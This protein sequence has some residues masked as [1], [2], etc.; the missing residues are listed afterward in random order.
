MYI[1]ILYNWLTIFANCNLLTQTP[2]AFLL[3][4]QYNTSAPLREKTT[5]KFQSRK[6]PHLSVQQNCCFHSTTCRGHRSKPKHH[7]QLWK[8]T[9]GTPPHGGTKNSP[10]DH[11]EK[12]PPHLEGHQLASRLWR[13]ALVFSCAQAC[14][15]KAGNTFSILNAWVF[16][17]NMA[18]FFPSKICWE[19]KKGK[20]HFGWDF[21]LPILAKVAVCEE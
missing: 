6:L 10:K 20:T 18:C 15:W 12:I 7:Q 8:H 13:K 19:R 17:R 16:W 3:L 4:K 14:A 21:D 5:V 2:N 11:M 1:Y 9:A